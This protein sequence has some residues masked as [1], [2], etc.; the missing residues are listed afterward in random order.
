MTLQEQP[1]AVKYRLTGADY[2]LLAEAGA[3]DGIRTELIDGEVLLMSPQ[4]R[5]HGM[6]KMRLLRQLDRSLAESGSSLEA[7]VEFTLALGMHDMP[8]PDIMLTSEPEGAGAV[9]LSSAA[10]VVE[11][12]HTTL[13]L[14]LGRKAQ[15]YAAAGIPEYWVADVNGRV[16]HLHS[17]PVGDSYADRRVI[18]FG[19][20]V[21]AD[22]IP[23]L[24]IDTSEL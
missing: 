14:D 6:V 5:P 7:V 10:L 2:E 9:P 21:T 24:T 18:A 22:T 16:L 12:S 15:L 8:D 17:R 1:P 13:R 23:G 3:F 4:H 19:E 20:P 11:V